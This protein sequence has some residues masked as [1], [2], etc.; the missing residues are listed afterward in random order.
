MN[1]ILLLIPFLFLFACSGVSQVSEAQTLRRYNYLKD[2]VDVLDRD[3]I[4]QIAVGTINLGFTKEQVIAARG[5]P[6]SYCYGTT[7]SSWGDTW[8]YNPFGTSTYGIGHGTYIYFNKMGNV[9]GWS[10]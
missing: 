8:E 1:K 6:C 3:V 10:N 9:T 5:E 2:K 4:N 7:E